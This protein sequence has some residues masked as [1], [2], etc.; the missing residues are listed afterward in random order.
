MILVDTSVWIDHWH[1]GNP[2]LVN[3]LNSGMVLLYPFVAGEIAL[4]NL[5]QP[6]RTSCP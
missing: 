2:L 3:L 1:R 6:R 4:G 5:R